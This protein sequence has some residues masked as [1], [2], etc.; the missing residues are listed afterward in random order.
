MK[1]RYDIETLTQK[2]QEMNEINKSILN[3]LNN[4]DNLPVINNYEATTTNNDEYDN[5]MPIMNE[6]ELIE[7][8]RKLV[9][10]HF[11]AYVVCINFYFIVL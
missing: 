2:Q 11:K 7:F 3:L 10:T 9:N 4:V 6:D 1:I 8:E 5:Y